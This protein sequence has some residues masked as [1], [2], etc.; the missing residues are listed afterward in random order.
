MFKNLFLG[1][2]V[3][4]G[5]Y[6]VAAMDS[7]L[8]RLKDWTPMIG[9]MPFPK[10]ANDETEEHPEP[11]ALIKL[12]NALRSLGYR[13]F[14][15]KNQ[16][17]MDLLYDAYKAGV[18][19]PDWECGDSNAQEGWSH[20]KVNIGDEIATRCKSGDMYFVDKFLD[21]LDT[22]VELV[23]NHHDGDFIAPLLLGGTDGLSFTLS[24]CSPNF[25]DKYLKC[26]KRSDI[27]HVL[28]RL[29]KIRGM[30]GA[31]PNLLRSALYIEGILDTDEGRDMLNY[32]AE[33]LCVEGFTLA[34][35]S[36][37]R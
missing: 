17:E 28:T 1:I 35:Q 23:V 21:H 10:M 7:A 6:G 19:K 24:M 37:H 14:M 30:I 36:A 29:D 8:E 4:Y 3:A 18:F 16:E 33:Y 11:E 25:S 26:L 5:V 12:H 32:A 31:R 27:C 15:P 9:D 13:C 20:I 34:M 22:F 2:A